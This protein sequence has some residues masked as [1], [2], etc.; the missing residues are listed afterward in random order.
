MTLKFVQITTAVFDRMIS[1]FK[2]VL[3]NEE[4]EPDRLRDALKTLNEKV[5]HQ[6]CQYLSHYILDC[7]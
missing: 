6:V 1:K 5:P 3:L 4:L 7:V 2:E